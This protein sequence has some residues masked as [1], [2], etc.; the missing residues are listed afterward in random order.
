MS[1]WERGYG[2]FVMGPDLDTLRP[3]P[4]QEGTALCLADVRGRTARRRRL[5]APDPAPP[6]R[7]AGRARLD[8]RT[9]APSSSSSSSATP[10]RRR[11][12]KG[13]RDLEP[14]Q[15]LQRRLLAARHRAR[16][17]ADPPDPQRDGRRRACWS[18]TPRASATSAST[19]STSTTPTRCGPP[20]STRSTRTAPRRSPPRRA[21][22]SPSWRSST[23]ARATR[24]TSTSRCADDDGARC[25]PTSRAVFDRFLAGQL[26]CLRELTLLLAP[27]V[28]SYKR[29]AAGSFAPTAV[30]WGTRQPHVLA[31][32]RRPRAVAARR[33]PRCR[34]RRQP[35]PRAERDDRRRPARHRRGARARAA[36]RGQRVRSRQA[37]RADDAARRARPVRRQRGRAR[38]VRRGGRRRTTSTTPDVELDG[39][40]RGGHRLGARARL[41]AACERVGDG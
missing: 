31:A 37:A 20:T 18:R 27:N 7:A 10:T 26:A 35:V 36:V 39:V 22:R 9:P 33:E 15:P 3:V 17:A 41:R 11:G 6:A 29:F 34:R 5:A 28:N 30:A 40:R 2:D 14:G 21:W 23:S 24:A 4:W 19:R 25:S 13:Y 16:R 8:A 32:R 38:G 12:S 1:S